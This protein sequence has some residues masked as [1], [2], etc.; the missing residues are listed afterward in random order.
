MA[1]LYQVSSLF[2]G[3]QIEVVILSVVACFTL[4]VNSSLE[5]ELVHSVKGVQL[6][7]L[8]YR[9]NWEVKSL[10]KKTSIIARF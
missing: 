1:V 2:R 6:V 8:L 10:T 5:N 4:I 3:V 9:E 7:N